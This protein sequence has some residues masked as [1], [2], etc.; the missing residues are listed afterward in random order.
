M[1]RRDV[2]GAASRDHD[3][4]VIGGGIHGACVAL[5]AA[6]RGVAVVLVERGDFGEA[7]T[8]NSLRL[9]HG[10]LRYLQHLDLVRFRQ[11][12]AERRW[13]CRTFPELVRPQACLMPLYG[14]GLRRPAVFQAALAAEA[15]LSRGR[16]HGVAAERQLPRGRVLTPRETA[17]RFPLVDR[18]GLLGGGL[19]YDAAMVSSER[20]L[21]EILRWACSLGAIAI[22]YAEVVG[23]TIESGRVAGV[24]VRDRVR[25]GLYGLHARAVCNCAGPW[26]PAVAAAAGRDAGAAFPPSLAFNVLLDRDPPS[27]DAVAVTAGNR[28]GRPTY[29]VCP[30]GSGVLAGTV[31]LPWAGGPDGAAPT[32]A[33]VA[34]FLDALNAAMPGF[35]ARPEHVRRVLAGLLPAVRGGSARLARRPAIVQHVRSGGPA[36]LVS[37]IGVKFTTARLV[38]R[39]AL[40]AL[41]AF[42]PGTTAVTAG[43]GPAVRRLPLEAPPRLPLSEADIRTVREIADEE[44]VTTVDDLVFRRTNWALTAPDLEALRAA[45]AASLGP[46]ERRRHREASA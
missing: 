11:S 35:G 28:P 38:A 10:G 3:L 36:G 29:F 19:W 45:V 42:L 16:N 8:W 41:R 43:P 7:T 4:I 12:V 26:V 39:Q 32:P 34:G 20:L 15:W 21:V 31:H 14:K 46:P 17:A 30:A 44:S 25:G 37:V 18:A 1:I 22:N 24:Q 13:F 9:L 5:E 27:R 2:R 6:R 33:A 40:E 23:L